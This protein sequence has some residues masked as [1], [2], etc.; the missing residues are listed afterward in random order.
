MK[1]MKCLYILKTIKNFSDFQNSYCK[2]IQKFIVINDGTGDM[3][4]SLGAH[5]GFFCPVDIHEN[6]S[7]YVLEFDRPQ[8]I[9]RFETEDVT[10]LLLHQKKSLIE[11]TEIQLSDSFFSDG[12][13]LLGGIDADW[14]RL[15]SKK[16]DCGVQVGIKDFTYMA[17]WGLAQRMTFICL[18][19]WCGTS[20]FVDTDHVW[21]TKIGNE[22]LEAGGKWMR[23]L[24]YCVVTK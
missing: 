16:S 1:T 13:K 6:T 24:E 2:L 7:D 22:H 5:P 18:E 9:Y 3:S 20:D 23:Q 12:P 11:G 10:K 17:L 4:F 15:Q 19:P 21:E 8:H 14:I